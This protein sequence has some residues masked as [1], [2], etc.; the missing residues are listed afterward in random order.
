[1]GVEPTPDNVQLG[2]KVALT[3]FPIGV[4]GAGTEA[5]GFGFTPQEAT[6]G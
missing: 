6:H 4:D 5:I 2:M 3:T 1:V